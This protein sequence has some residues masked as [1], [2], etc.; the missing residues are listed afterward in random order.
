MPEK[1][2]LLTAAAFAASG[3]FAST[4]PAVGVPKGCDASVMSD[5]YWQVWNEGEQ[6][7]IDADI[8]ANRK[9]DGV[10]AVPAADGTIVKIEQ[11]EHDFKFGAHIFNF[12][13]LG[14]KECNDAY[15]S[16][17][18]PG[19]IFNSATV[20]FYWSNYEPTPGH[21]RA[22]GEYEDSERFWNSLSREEA[23]DHPY[24]RRPAPGPVVDFCK[25]RGI[26]VHGHVLVWGSAKPTW[27]YDQFCP[28]DEKEA[29]APW[30]LRRH[31]PLLESAVDAGAY[32]K[33]WQA[34]WKR[35][36]DDLTEEEIAARAPVFTRRMRE[37]FRS[38]V[39]GVA[40]RFGD[41]VDSWD[42][43]NESSCDWARYRKSRTEKP[44]W[45]SSYGLM[46]GDYPLHALLD[47]KEFIP[48]RAQ[49]NVNDYNICGDFRD[50]VSD[51]ESEG[52]KIDVVGCQ[53]HIFNTNDCMRLALGETDVN[54][55]GSPKAISDRLDMM[56]KT[57]KP[58]H[59]SEV[60]ITSP[61][62]DARSRQIQAVLARNIYRAWFA[63]K[64][65]MGITWWNTVDG[66]GVKGEPLVSGLFT[67]DLKKKPAYL[68]LDELINSEW[69]TKT[70]ATARNGKIAF[71]GF[72]G[73]YRLSWTGPD[74]LT[75]MRTVSL[76][77]DGGEEP[78]SSQAE[79]KKLERCFVQIPDVV[80]APKGV[81]VRRVAAAGPTGTKEIAISGG[82][83]FFDL[84]KTLGVDVQQGVDGMNEPP[85]TLTFEYDA[86]VRTTID[87]YFA[88]DWY[89][90]IYV[91]GIEASGILDGPCPPMWGVRPLVLEKGRNTIAF[92]THHGTSGQWQVGLAYD[93]R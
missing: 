48:P 82:E 74:G 4:A 45:R 6:A 52:A 73:K 59:V 8:E 12:N 50:Q 19:G 84:E 64:S 11:I 89:G 37:M 24:W 88:N 75:R 93:V 14:G 9:A 41:V 90:R 27:I 83:I 60:T 62:S 47:A 46:P 40:E 66:C 21:L 57:G 49:L 85:V 35:I 28:E 22:N 10:F 7:R 69:K 56:A 86:K 79:A 2:C 39:K 30:G 32:A 77:G 23:M 65:L 20:A 55:V 81:V 67:R 18:G 71:R 70:E 91:N 26:R 5:R 78:A 63:H 76:T 15:K 25:Q 51:L 42:V 72:R 13:Q 1:S 44:V 53:M 36:C 3:L 92:E 34:T 58:I 68:A 61:G 17:Y 29:F 31:D 16:S 43:V 87:L 54:W 38:R 33:H 80:K